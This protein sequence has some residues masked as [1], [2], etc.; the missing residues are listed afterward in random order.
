MHFVV[1]GGGIAGVCC[2]EEL[3]RLAPSDHIILVSADRTL[4]VWA[5]MADYVLQT[6]LTCVLL[7]VE[8]MTGTLTNLLTRLIWHM[9]WCCRGC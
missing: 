9:W 2:A 7:K 4:K 6:Q 8:R 3:C 5:H 1:I